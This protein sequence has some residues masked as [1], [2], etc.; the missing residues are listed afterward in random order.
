MTHFFEVILLWNFPNSI[1][2]S[3]I[4]KSKQGKNNKASR[5]EPLKPTYIGMNID[6]S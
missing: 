5:M 4:N 3:Y 2:G 6:I 1:S